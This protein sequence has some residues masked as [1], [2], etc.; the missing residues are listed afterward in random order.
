MKWFDQLLDNGEIQLRGHV[1]REAGSYLRNFL[2]EDDET[3]GFLIFETSKKDGYVSDST[4][5]HQISYGAT[6]RP[7]FEDGE[8]F[9]ITRNT[10]DHEAICDLTPLAVKPAM[11]SEIDE[12]R[13][14][15]SA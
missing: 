3:W 10:K 9:L 2:D 14:I 8:S 4:S 5:I 6:F 1:L 15:L 12:I 7:S 13:R 11:Q